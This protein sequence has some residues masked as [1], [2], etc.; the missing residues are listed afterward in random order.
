L[1]AIKKA[2]D[3]DKAACQVLIQHAA[4][5]VPHLP[6]PRGRPLDVATAKH[7]LL[8]DELHYRGRPR[9]FTWNPV[10]ENF[11][12]PATQATRT[13]VGNPSFDPRFAARR[14]KRRLNESSQS[15][16]DLGQPTSGL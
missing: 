11:V 10:E 3:R 9:A 6:D 14:L 13:A 15:G 2:A 5:L 8:L 4:W 1:E 12:D 16:S 7:E